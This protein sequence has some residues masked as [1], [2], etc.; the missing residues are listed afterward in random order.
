MHRQHIVAEHL[1]EIADEMIDVA[2]PEQRERFLLTLI[3]RI[4]AEHCMT[5]AGSAAKCARRSV[6]P[7][8]RQ[9]SNKAFS[10]L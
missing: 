6:T 3:T 5:R 7:S 8:S 2:R 1:V 4:Q 9:R 10:A